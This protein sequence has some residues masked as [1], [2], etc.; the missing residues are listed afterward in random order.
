MPPEPPADPVLHALHAVGLAAAYPALQAAQARL[1]AARTRADRNT[2]GGDAAQQ[3]NPGLVLHHA[4]SYWLATRA[5]AYVLEGRDLPG[6]LLDVGAGAGAFSVWA[7]GL[8]ERPLVVAEPD[9]DH[10]RLAGRAFSEATVVADI[11]D[12]P[13]APIVVAMEVIEHIPRTDQRAFLAAF[14]GRVLPGGVAILSTPDESGF[15]GGWSGYAPHIGQVTAGQLLALLGAVT[16]WPAAVYRIHGPGFK[17]GALSRRTIPAV[18]RAWTGMQQHLP[19]PASFFMRLSARF[20]KRRSRVAHVDDAA[21]TVTP[22]SEGDGT[23]LIAVVRAP[24]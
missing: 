18:N 20:G 13:P 9:P 6:P 24:G 3:W 15:P 11:A 4:V 17:L 8:L 19:G 22:A 14:C 10:R 21:F 23:G 5:A 16:D 1:E 2:Q 7:A 12:A